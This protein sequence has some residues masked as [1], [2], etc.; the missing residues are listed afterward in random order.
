MSERPKLIFFTT[1]Y[2]YGKSEKSFVEPE[3]ELLRESYD[4]TIVTLA[5]DYDFVE[6][7]YNTTLPDD[8][9]LVHATNAAPPLQVL[10]DLG[11]FVSPLGWRELRELVQDGFTT[12]RLM[13]SVFAF[14]HAR[15]IVRAL[16][17]YGILD[18]DA[19]PNTVF[20]S[21]WINNAVLALAL[22]KRRIPEL[23]FLCRALGADL[24]N[25]RKEHGRQP[26]QRIKRD[27]CA[28]ILFQSKIPRDEFIREFG[29][30]HHV[31]QY[32]VNPLGVKRSVPYAAYDPTAPTKT[33]ASCSNVIPLK[34]V[35]LIARAI[36]SMPEK[37]H[38]RWVHFGS[39]SELESVQALARE[40]G[41][42]ATFKGYTVNADI[43]AYYQTHQI[44]VFVHTS[45]TEGG[46]PVA[47]Q[48]AL[49][50]GLPVVGTSVGGLPDSIDGNGILLATDPTAQEVAEAIRKVVFAP[51]A[52][53][54]A[55]RR[56]SHQLWE[57]HFDQVANKGQLMELLRRIRYKPLTGGVRAWMPRLAWPP[58]APQE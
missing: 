57:D 55:M 26:F 10:Y 37:E 43:C 19:L 38:L 16:R 36:A 52:D 20:Y 54:L 1:A 44:D 28:F 41:V 12:Q 31:G 4:V 56:A 34:R 42:D 32:V 27:A 50:A 23:Q 21:F 25:D 3:L 40:L 24:Y 13:D 51:P 2:P 46:N 49:A 6:S 17:R 30:Q 53:I 58:V 48:E 35:D 39:G 22:A 8:V 7:Q 18:K 45:A 9:T 5:R 29:P 14:G 15:A 11:M 33:I 47:V